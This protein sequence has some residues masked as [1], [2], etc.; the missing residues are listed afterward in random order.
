MVQSIRASARKGNWLD[1][2]PAGAYNTA[3]MRRS[4]CAR[5]HLAAAPSLGILKCLVEE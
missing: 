4:G 3:K 2:L 1:P 5:P